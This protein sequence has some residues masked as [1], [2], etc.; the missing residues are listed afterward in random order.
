LS[1]IQ[2]SRKAKRAKIES[3][4]GDEQDQKK[5]AEPTRNMTILGEDV[6]DPIKQPAKKVKPAMSPAKPPGK[7]FCVWTTAREPGPPRIGFPGQI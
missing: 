6:V 3:Q 2:R 5:N 4:I 7:G 1:E